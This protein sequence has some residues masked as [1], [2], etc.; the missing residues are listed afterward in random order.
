MARRLACTDRRI[1]SEAGDALFN[2]AGEGK[3]RCETTLRFSTS[4]AAVVL[5]VVRMFSPILAILHSRKKTPLTIAIRGSS[6]G[7]DSLH[8]EVQAILAGKTEPII[9]KSRHNLLL[10]VALVH[11]LAE[12]QKLTCLQDLTH[13]RI[14][15]ALHLGSSGLNIQIVRIES[16]APTLTRIQRNQVA[17]ALASKQVGRRI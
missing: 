7:N 4:V 5:L 12:D 10:R 2:V 1:N 13:A 17:G 8:T 16:T 9:A 6:E 3:T 14:V 11:K 15:T